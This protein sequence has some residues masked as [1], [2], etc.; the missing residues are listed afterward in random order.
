MMMMMM[1]RHT[2]LVALSISIPRKYSLNKLSHTLYLSLSLKHSITRAY[3]HIISLPLFL[4]HIQI[5]IHI[6]HPLGSYEDMVSAMYKSVRPVT[7]SAVKDGR[8]KWNRQRKHLSRNKQ[9]YALLSKSIQY[10]PVRFPFFI[11][12]LI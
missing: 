5:C 2:T 9:G 7:Y 12:F 1:M 3:K 6:L 4:P 11:L 10:N 8:N